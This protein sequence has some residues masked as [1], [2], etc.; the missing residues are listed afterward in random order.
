MRFPAPQDY[1]RQRHKAVTLLGMSGVGKTTLAARLPTDRWFHYSGDYRIGTKYLAEPI[2]DNVKEQAM[3]VP[4]LREL[5]R[6][7]SIYI[8]NNITIH[9]LEPVSTFLGKLGDP[10]KGG[11]AVEE[12]KRR[13]RLHRKAEIL[14]MRDVEDFIGKA[15]RIYGY[16]HFINDAGG[17]LC[18]IVD[19]DNPQDTVLPVLAR[20]TLILYIKASAEQEELLRQRARQN[21]KPL[22]YR[23]DFLDPQIAA[24]LAETGAGSVAE[25]DP[26]RFVAWIFPR[27]VAHRLPRYQAFADR[28]GYTV[29]A[30]EV[31]SVR[32]E[33]DFEA[34]IGTAIGRAAS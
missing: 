29:S 33:R 2:L 6:S 18:E 26:N 17:S 24:F 14:A 27:L 10:A 4:F 19:L 28:H 15:Q 16:D 5:L 3:Q 23:E 20:S 22:F 25:I 31:A 11:L 34:L 1:A 21:P 8:C 9:N 13:Q 30:D 32:D 12:F 7:D